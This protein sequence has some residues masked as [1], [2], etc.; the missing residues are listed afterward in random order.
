M[1]L[2]DEQAAAA[3]AAGGTLVPEGTQVAGMGQAGARL[4]QSILEVATGKGGKLMGAARD[5]AAADMR[6]ALDESEAPAPGVAE[7][8]SPSPE[9][10]PAGD[11]APAAVEEVA[12]AIVE[13]PQ[14]AFPRVTEPEVE[15]PRS[16]TENDPYDR[17]QMDVQPKNR[18]RVTEED[19]EA[20]LAAPGQRQ[21]DMESPVALNETLIDFNENRLPDENAVLARIGHNSEAYAGQ[22]DEA[23]RGKIELETTRQM[24]DLI[25]STPEKVRAIAE[26][27]L[28]REEGQVA[29]V[30]GMGLAETMLAQRELLVNEMR[31]LDDLAA[32]VH[33]K[34]ANLS[35]GGPNEML[36]FRSQMELV[37]NL[38]MQFKGA[39]T[40]MARALSA[41]RIPVRSMEG[42]TP[43]Q[44]R[45]IQLMQNRD[46][47]LLLEDQ[48]GMDSIATAARLYQQLDTADQ[49]ASFARGLH[50]RKRIGDAVFEVWQHA[51]LTN[52]VTHSKNTVGNV[53]T[54]LVLPNAELAVAAGFGATRRAMGAKAIDTVQLEDVQAQLFGQLMAMGEA[55]RLA[56]R[57]F[58]VM[59]PQGV[60]GSKIDKVRQT[61]FGPAPP[62]T[63]KESLRSGSFASP[64]FPE[65]Q[66]SFWQNTIDALGNIVTLGRVSF[67]GLEMGDTW[68]K[69]VSMRGQIY[70]EALLSGRARGLDG[71]ELTNFISDFISTPPAAAMTRAEAVA[72]YNTLQT[73]LD[74]VGRSFQTIS[75]IPLM[76]YMMPFIKTPYNG[77]KYS[78]VDRTALGS[79]WGSTGAMMRA[80]G[81]Q[82]DEAMARITLGTTMGMLGVLYAAQSGG[83]MTGG[84]PSDRG[85]KQNMRAEGWA[86]YRAPIGGGE[87]INYNIEPLGGM[88]GLYVDAYELLSAKDDWDEMELNDIAGAVVGA[89]LYNVSNKSYLQQFATLG[90]VMAEPDRYS[91]RVVESLIKSMVP[92]A[93]AGLERQIDP[94]VREAKGV[95]DSL[96]AQVPG[97]STDLKPMVDVF[98]NDVV[99]GVKVGENSY[100]LALGPDWASPFYI[101]EDRSTP[102]TKELIRLGGVKLSKQGDEIKLPA[103]DGEGNILAPDPIQLPD[104][105][106]YIFQKLAGKRGKEALEAFISTPEYKQ[107]ADFSKGQNKASKALRERL[108]ERLRSVYNAAKEAALGEFLSDD[109]YG[110]V[111]VNI[112]NMLVDRQRAAMAPLK[113][114][115]N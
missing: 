94:T 4:G 73:D 58:V 115:E 55:S 40:E 101:S 105:M 69:V 33:D 80:G 59:Q 16:L 23:K 91:G 11:P 30:K 100:N 71:D 104:E 39:Q 44:M 102:L 88:I 85:L 14:A 12:P 109:V 64:R 28:A 65:A 19:V 1:A 25:G 6:R 41:F 61:T 27:L 72:K 90:K 21:A 2:I 110:E 47:S 35:L 67:R 10:S 56:G 106:R 108:G 60:P 77:F 31:K 5:K 103:D 52:P 76:R 96:K 112:H 51:L 97:L 57:A 74:T 98:G 36:Q 49:R 46:L 68:F 107:A 75:R 15:I 18:I 9:V 99:P 22:I 45:N 83:E 66:S 53:L 70:K 62:E 13:E 34:D 8:V 89:T 95:L 50:L 48:G 54:T 82:R 20:S 86:P 7:E 38:Q 42:A 37:A 114:L 78:F 32:K 92:R 17:Y 24:A 26:S 113:E 43:E 87:Y 81:K 79:L 3:S 63:F 111:I 29:Q 84:G 93:V